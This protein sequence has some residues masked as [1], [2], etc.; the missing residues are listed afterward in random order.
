MLADFL[1]NTVLKPG[2]QRLG[3]VAATALVAGGDKLC[4]MIP[5]TC[6]LVTQSG[7]H[8]VMLWVTS[9]AFIAFDLALIHL[10]RKSQ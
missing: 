6:G 1:K 8:Q 5:A 2:L 10:A 7:A 3:T 4:Q 9:A